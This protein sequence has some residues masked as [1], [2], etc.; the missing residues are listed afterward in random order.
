MNEYNDYSLRPYNTFGFD[1]KCARFIELNSV[2]D[3]RHAVNLL[4]K[5]TYCNRPCFV[6]GGG[7]NLVFASDYGG[8]ILHSQIKGHEVVKEEDGHVFLRVGSGENWDDTAAYCTQNHW[9][10]TE[11]LALIPGEMGAASI[12]NIGAYGAEIKDLIEKVEAVDLESGETKT[13]TQE[14]CHYAY[15]K[16][17]F[18][19]EWKGRFL[20]TYVTLKLSTRFQPD[21]DYGNIKAELVKE[22][23]L[24]SIE[25]KDYSKV[26]AL[27][28]REAVIRIRKA[29]LPD[30]KEIG[31]AGSFFM[32]PII[33][34]ILY[35]RL[36]KRFP[37]MPHYA[38]PDG[39]MKIP[40]GWLI[41]QCGWKG[42]RV[43]NVG[44]YPKQALVLVNWG[45]GTGID[46]VAL[47]NTI[48]KEV[49]RKFNIEIIPEA[50]IIL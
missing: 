14:E 46:I 39:K 30:P 48:R 36:I 15:R 23:L 50:N 28:L 38:L 19:K 5:P 29:K 16:S 18:K 1:V 40:A 27:H 9:Y 4:K 2:D 17:I 3:V 45:G 21:L 33:P 49:R 35:D 22:G 47:S 26:T 12:Q 13:F 10:G 43:G 25:D 37:T 42:K 20:I 44:V 11:N 31:S 7:S 32:N 24:A 34:T 6:M 41:E 8:T